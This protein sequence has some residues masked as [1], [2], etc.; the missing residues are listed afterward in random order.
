MSAILKETIMIKEVAQTHPTPNRLGQIAYWISQIGSPP[1]T[2]TVTALLIGFSL[3]TSPGWVWVLFYIALTILIPCAYITWLVY[4]GQ[5]VD[6]HLPKRE[7]RIR[8]LLL[9]LVT[10]IITWVVLYYEDAPP[11]LQMLAAINGVQMALFL[12]ITFYW[13]ISLHCTAATIL[14]VVAIAIFGASAVP[15]TMSIPIIA[16][17]RV[18]L[19]RHTLAQTIAGIFLGIAILAPALFIYL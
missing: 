7:Q 14:A 3:A 10:G 17:S 1:L 15:F 18:Y 6:F 13:K 8:P 5:A 2:G 4:A 19:R 9:S 16:W 11:I 12:V